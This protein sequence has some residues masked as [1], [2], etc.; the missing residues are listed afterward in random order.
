MMR[1]SSIA[2]TPTRSSMSSRFG[3]GGL[4]LIRQ[5]LPPTDR[6][7][8]ARNKFTRSGI[9][10][11]TPPNELRG[12]DFRRFVVVGQRGTSRN[13]SEERGKLELCT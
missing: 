11:P 5:P 8:C 10:M 7:A 4:W 13:T 3:A 9:A 12:A 1:V 6:N 2:T